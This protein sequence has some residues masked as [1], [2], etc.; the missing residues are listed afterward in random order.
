MTLLHVTL[1]KARALLA[2]DSP[3]YAFEDGAD[4]ADVCYRPGGPPVSVEKL[5][6]VAHLGVVATGQGSEATIAA[7]FAAV[8]ERSTDLD[9]AVEWLPGYLRSVVRK[10]PPGQQRKHEGEQ[11]APEACQPRYKGCG[12]IVAG[13][14]WIRPPAIGRCCRSPA[15]AALVV[16]Q[17]GSTGGFTVA[18]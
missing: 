13:G 1:S 3:I 4:A 7:A 6:L 15:L 11:S 2:S 16:R 5:C 9:D 17:A 8:R 18:A 12:V 14:K 10:M